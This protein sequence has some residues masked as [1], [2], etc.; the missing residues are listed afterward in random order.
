MKIKKV[1]IL[2][3]LCLSFLCI[4][5]KQALATV[6]ADISGVISGMEKV[7]QAT[8]TG[9]IARVL[10]AVIKLIQI[11]GTGISVLMV[12]M[13]GVKYMLSSSSEKAEIKKSMQPIL[14]GCVLLFA[15]VNLVAVIASVGASLK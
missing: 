11:A 12:T 14:I 5:P 1:L 13:L 15:A 2:L 9:R 4:M 7:K 3:M 6:D 8:G 10:N